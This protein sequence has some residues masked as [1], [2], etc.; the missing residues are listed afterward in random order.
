MPPFFDPAYKNKEL[1]IVLAHPDDEIIFTNSILKKASKIIICFQD[2]PGEKDISLGRYKSSLNYPLNNFIQL[3]L[4]QA[5]FSGKIINW[6]N[7]KEI[8]YGIDGYLNRRDYERNFYD[9]FEKLS[10]LLKKDILVVTHNPWGE[11]GHPEHIQVNRVI[12]EIAEIKKFNYFVTG[13]ASTCNQKYAFN[14]M[15]KLGDKYIIF[16]TDLT[17]FKKI[18]DLYMENNCWTW[19]EFYDLPKNEIF[20]EQI[21]KNKFINQRMKKISQYPVYLINNGNNLSR[22]LLHILKI[23]MPLF[24]QKKLRKLKLRNDK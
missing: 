14:Q 13:I 9:L 16:E 22:N 3:G 6:D 7:P 10:D 17:L 8:K 2:I 24:L 5:R 21:N 1:Y 4:K 23:F 12:S 11:Y 20:F 15:H 19:F 18:K